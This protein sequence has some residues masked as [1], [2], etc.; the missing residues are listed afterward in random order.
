MRPKSEE[1]AAGI[2]AQKI[3]LRCVRLTSIE[4]I[5]EGKLVR[6]KV[7]DYSDVKV[8]TPFGEIPW[9]EVSRITQEEMK[10]FNKEVVNKIYTVLL[11]LGRDRELPEGNHAFY[12]PHD[13][14]APEIDPFIEKIFLKAETNGEPPA[15]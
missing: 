3:A 8:V 1:R 13:W 12:V 7:G 5:H 14:D 15:K 4:K 9:S 10:V 6:T 11:M 2:V